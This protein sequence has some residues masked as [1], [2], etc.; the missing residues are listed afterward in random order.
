L[1]GVRHSPERTARHPGFHQTDT[2]DYALVLEGE[3]WAVLD[4]TETLLQAGD[5]LIQ[6]G[7]FHAWDN[8]SS[9]VCRIAF[10][11]I[12]AEPLPT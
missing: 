12:D 2:V 5:V 11:L 1:S 4:D 7:T 10:I 8:R 6:R 3:V 9:T